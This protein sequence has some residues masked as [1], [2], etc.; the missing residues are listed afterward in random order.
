MKLFEYCN[1]SQD[2]NQRSSKIPI[3]RGKYEKFSNS[4]RKE[5]CLLLVLK[6]I[7][8]PPQFLPWK[9]ILWFKQTALFRA[10]N[11]LRNHVQR[12][13]SVS[14][15]IKISRRFSINKTTHLEPNKQQNS[16]AHHRPYKMTNSRK[17]KGWPQG[18]GKLRDKLIFN[19]IILVCDKTWAITR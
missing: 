15:I 13:L 3:M 10:C 2:W 4:I 9:K 6:V 5:Y 14:E 8:K 17:L 7:F 1:L 18:I 12:L 19:L 11:L 16:S